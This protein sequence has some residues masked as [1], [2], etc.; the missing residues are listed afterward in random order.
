[1][2][3]ES[4]V[5]RKGAT[6]LRG[7]HV[8]ATTTDQRLLDQSQDTDWLHTDPWRV[9]RI[10][11]EFVEGFGTLA[12]IG[13]AVS[14]FGSARIKPDSDYYAKGVELGRLLADAGYAVITGGGP[15]AMEAANKG[16]FEAGGTSVGLGIELPFESGLN[17][18]VDLGVNFRY[19]FARKTMFVKYAQGYVVLPGGFGTLDEL[20]EAVTLAQT[21]KVTSFP[22]VLLGK[23][24][25]TPMINFIRDTLYAEGMVGEKDIHRLQIVDDPAEAVRII[26]SDGENLGATRPE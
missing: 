9:M 3:N 14:V 4:E 2:T 26:T 23:G 17:P 10:Q 25:W 22:I 19:F 1:M 21:Q 8:P 5:Y 16:A 7:R 18:Y 24:F 6:T 11:A 20:F 13:P 12:E 15:G